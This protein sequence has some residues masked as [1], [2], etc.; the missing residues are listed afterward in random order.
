MCRGLAFPIGSPDDPASLHRVMSTCST[1]LITRNQKQ[2]RTQAKPLTVGICAA[3]ELL[4]M[5]TKQILKILPY[6]KRVLS[7]CWF[8][9]FV[10]DCV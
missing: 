2:G 1:K 4:S 8:D 7:T 6:W 10:A 3:L 9:P 5:H